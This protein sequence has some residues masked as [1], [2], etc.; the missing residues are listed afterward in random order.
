VSVY[1]IS[2]T[3]GKIEVSLRPSRIAGEADDDEEK[4]KAGD[5]VKGYVAQTNKKGCFIKLRNGHS[6]RV[7]LKDLSDGF[8]ASPTASF[9]PGRL[10]AGKVE[11]IVKDQIN[12]NLRESAVVGDADKLTFDD[13]DEGDKVPGIITRLEPYGAFV[14]F[15][16]SDVSGLVHVSELSDDFVEDVSNIFSPGDKVIAV[17]L[18]KV[19]DGEKCKLSLGLKQSYFKGD[20]EEGSS[21]EEEDDDEDADEGLKMVDDSSDD[22]MPDAD[23]D[24]SDASD[25]DDS[26]D[27][28]E[29]EGL[30]PMDVS[31]DEDDLNSDDDDYMEKLAKKMA[32]SQEDSDEEGSDED[33]SDS[34]DSDDDAGFEW[35]AG[36]KAASSSKKQQ[37][38]DSE[39][40]S[41]S[42]SDDSDSDDSDAGKKSNKKQE[43]KD[44]EALIAAREQALADGTADS[45]P[46]SA[47]DFERLLAAEPNSSELWIRFMAFYLSTADYEKARQVADRAVARIEYTQEDEKLNVY[48]AMI[49]MELNFG[50]A[51]S[52]QESILN[53][54]KNNNGKKVYL[55]T[56]ELFV[57]SAANK[58]GKDAKDAMER[59]DNH[60]SVMCKKFK[61]KNQVWIAYC[62]WLVQQGKSKEA[63]DVLKRSLL[64]LLPHKH[65]ETMS[66]FA[67]FEYE[68]GSVERGRTV[69]EGLLSKFPK[70]LDLWYVF[71]DKE[72]K[73][74]EMDSVRR[75]FKKIVGG[76][77]TCGA[78]FSDT[79]MKGVF[80]KWLGVEE[81]HGD[82]KSCELVKQEAK[83]YVSRVAK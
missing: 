37:K 12:L 31:D 4:P 75:V 77:E 48:M 6:A 22:E 78:K 10:I 51:S 25:S 35:G 21:S 20:E 46:E 5:I 53:G 24:D 44:A 47:A 73:A 69:F 58:T 50:T 57:S 16:N 55:R 66:K 56:A 68:F 30:Q 7:V 33:D 19:I 34:D 8:V 28:D 76:A 64:S 59:I 36:K 79:Q 83:K 39:S 26:D 62:K 70:K 74:G 61:T 18:K 27:S 65:V 2:T 63:N 71:V 45:N 23:S 17:V 15:L 60:M 40:D 14:K 49:A 13:F 9:P 80:K 42:D 3:D 52:L 54:A 41:D 43:K 82:K 81:K 38:A 29:D 67:Q 1:V 32:Q 11:K 72:V